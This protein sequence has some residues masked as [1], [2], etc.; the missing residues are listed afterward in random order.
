MAMPR[1]PLWEHRA[2]LPA[3]GMNGEKEALRLTSG[4]VCTNP[5]QL[6]PSK[7]MPWAETCSARRLSRSRPSSPTSEKKPE[8]TI[9]ALTPA[10]A[11]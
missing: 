10:A 2:A 5:M 1:A 8:M 7:R 3:S 11:H 6:G 9:R 4:S